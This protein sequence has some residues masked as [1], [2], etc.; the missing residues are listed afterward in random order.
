MIAR[1]KPHILAE[2]SN[3]NLW[4]RPDQDQSISNLLGS[5]SH[6]TG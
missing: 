6:G 2:I 1:M 3:S 5:L 4:Q